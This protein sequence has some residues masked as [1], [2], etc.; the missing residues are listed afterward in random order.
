MSAD[1]ANYVTGTLLKE[2]LADALKKAI[3]EGRLSPGQRVVEA[4]WSAE[5][6]VAHASIREAINLLI[7]EGFLV[8][9][10]GRSARVVNYQERD[11]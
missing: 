7:G 2:N 5:F 9:D 3:F 11:V 4:T 8:K 6:R 10:A 1:R